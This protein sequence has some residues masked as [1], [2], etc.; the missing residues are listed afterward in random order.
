V[1]VDDI[2]NHG[3]LGV[4]EGVCKY[5]QTYPTLVP[6]AVGFNKMLFVKL[7]FKEYYYNAFNG[8]GLKDK[9]S[10]FFGHKIIVL[11]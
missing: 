3:W 4:M 5:I 10:K 1:I 8:F 7:S 2:S 11:S 6:V 9:E